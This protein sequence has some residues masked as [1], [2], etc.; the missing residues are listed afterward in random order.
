MALLNKKNKPVEEVVSEETIEKTDKKDVK[1]SSFAKIKNSL[2]F[3][4][5]NAPIYVISIDI[6][7]KVIS[8][9]NIIGS[10]LNTVNITKIPYKAKT[11]NEE[12]FDRIFKKTLKFCNLFVL[13]VTYLVRVDM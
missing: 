2:P 5:K 11:L 12:F 1:I 8:I 9:M 7:E 10:D 13:L 3:L 6:Y 4:N